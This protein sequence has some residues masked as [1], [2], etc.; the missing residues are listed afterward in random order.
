MNTNDNYT[1]LTG[2][3]IYKFI[4]FGGVA[5]LMLWQSKTFSTLLI[6]SISY[7]IGILFD[8]LIIAQ[9]N[10]GPK[11]KMRKSFSYILHYFLMAAIVIM[12]FFLIGNVISDETVQRILTFIIY[13]LVVGYTI[14]GFVMEIISN[15]PANN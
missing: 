7:L 15:R 10:N 4:A 14:L 13:I 12:L 2:T 8:L 6:G 3:Y 5:A 1:N 11:L 9:T